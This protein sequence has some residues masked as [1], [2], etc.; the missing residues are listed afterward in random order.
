MTCESWTSCY[1]WLW[2]PDL[3][4][5]LGDTSV[6]VCHDSDIQSVVSARDLFIPENMLHSKMLGWFI[7]NIINSKFITSM[8]VLRACAP[9]PLPLHHRHRH[10]HHHCHHPRH[11]HCHHP[12]HHHYFLATATFTVSVVA[13]TSADGRWMDDDG[14][15]LIATGVACGPLYT[16]TP[17][18]PAP[19][20]EPSPS[21]PR[22][23][24]AWVPR[25]AGGA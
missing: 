25:R 5:L 12:H 4:L 21:V 6:C 23:T 17:A 15:G 19:P 22:K 3:P 2:V 11:H 8:P 16:L 20:A 18:R 9:S 24:R 13:A 10:R 14:M 7:I 1:L